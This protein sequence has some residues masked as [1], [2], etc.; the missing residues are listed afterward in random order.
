MADF[1]LAPIDQQ[2]AQAVSIDFVDSPTPVSGFPLGAGRLL[3]QFP[4]KILSDSKSANWEE[5]PLASFEPLSMWMGAA[6]R[7]ITMEITYVVSGDS[8]S[9]AQI[10][11][12]TKKVKAYFYRGLDK[13]AN[14]IPIVKLK[15]YDHVGTQSPADFRLL[16]VNITHG[17]TIIKDSKGVFPLLTKINISAA[18]VT[19]AEGKQH[20]SKLRDKPPQDWY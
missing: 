16:D 10:A 4:P 13:G 15:F 11:F 8:F 5:K 17:E 19:Q 2:L 20:I 14:D 9:T 3:L 12:Y 18:L 1:I 6:A 7:K